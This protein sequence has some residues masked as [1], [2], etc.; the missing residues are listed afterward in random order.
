VVNSA[1][2]KSA[3]LNAAARCRAVGL[4]GAFRMVAQ[5]VGKGRT[6]RQASSPALISRGGK[7]Y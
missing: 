6:A 2:S 3:P 7:G 4:A 5:Q 1:R